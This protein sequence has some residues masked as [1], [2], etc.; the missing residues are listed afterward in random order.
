MYEI[1][2][3]KAVR[4]IEVILSHNNTK[5]Y[6]DFKKRDNCPAVAVLPLYGLPFASP[7][8]LGLLLL[9]PAPFLSLTPARTVILIE[10]KVK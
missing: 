6:V 2:R 9:H 1:I 4:V 5:R 8:A 10:D 3:L 7:P